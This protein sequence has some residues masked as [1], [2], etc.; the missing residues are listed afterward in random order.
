M[1]T[2][3][4]YYKYRYTKVDFENNLLLMKLKK[5]QS[6]SMD[7]ISCGKSKFKS[8]KVTNTKSQN[9]LM[10]EL[11]KQQSKNEGALAKKKTYRRNLQKNYKQENK[12][13]II[14][15]AFTELAQ[16]MFDLV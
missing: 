7:N 15:S 12:G 10:Y 6:I 4:K 14:D 8:F 3:Q 16:K 13:V 11:L 1:S 9:V 5:S 2:R